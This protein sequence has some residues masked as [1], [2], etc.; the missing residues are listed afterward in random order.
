MGHLAVADLS[1]VDESA[2]AVIDCAGDPRSVA[3]AIANLRPQGIF[4][5]AGYEVAPA[6]D[7][8]LIARKELV[9]TGVRSG[10]R[11]DLEQI[12][13]LAA[14]GAIRLPPISDYPL[15]EINAA[16]A[17]LRAHDVPGKVVIRP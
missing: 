2:S 5:A 1:E 3:W 16:I 14:S 17:S 8:A 4:V 15:A 6:L 13:T 7:T 10:R 12:L 9:I 11:T